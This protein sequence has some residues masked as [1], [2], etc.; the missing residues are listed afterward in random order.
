MRGVRIPHDLN[1]DDRFLLGL[2]V[3]NL[4][5][6][7]FGLLGAYTVLHL[8]WPALLRDLLAI[9]IAGV[10]AAIAWIH[11]EGRSLL[12]WAGAAI[13]Y[14]FG[15]YRDRADLRPSEARPRLAVVTP[16]VV[17]DPMP[18]P[19]L[20]DDTV[21]EL[22]STAWQ[23]DD[24]PESFPG[25]DVAPAPVYLGGAQVV[26]FFSIK[27]GSGRTTLATEMA[28]LLASR[29][30]YR[31]SPG[32]RAERLKVALVDFDLGSANVSVRVGLA[33]P[34]VL[35]YL[36]G[37]TTRTRTVSD[38]LLTH[39][40]SGLRILLGMPKCITTQ[41]T[42]AFGV[43]QCAEILAALRSDGYHF[44]FID[45]SATLSDLTIYLL[46]A[47]DRIFYIVTPTAGSIQDLYRGVEALR[48][49]GLG[50]KLRYVANR[51]REKLDFAEP[52]GDLGGHLA[53]AIPYDTA[54][55]VAE[56]RHQPFVLSG[57]GETL[58]ALFALGRSIYPGLDVPDASRLGRLRW[59]ARP[60]HAG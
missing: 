51:M 56:N 27:G 15:S 17:P 38:Y 16:R 22:P 7:L 36:G 59:F 10:A 45:V 6:F 55:E 2:S 12:H 3:Q 21:L 1:G 32:A 34:T 28:C 42:L 20:A 48:R 4:A 26:T 50:R 37:L 40:R 54:F 14:R 19:Q 47:A 18:S 13:E 49:L 41:A 60:R 29:G 5:V 8:A 43:P 52:M 53:A 11:P 57:R 35:D 25:P 44:I 39:H 9:F 31:E 24:V 46:E 23:H 33:Q 58:H 30:W